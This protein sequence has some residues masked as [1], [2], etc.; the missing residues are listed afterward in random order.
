MLMAESYFNLTISPGDCI[1]WSGRKGSFRIEDLFLWTNSEL[2]GFA[3]RR[4]FRFQ[5][6][7]FFFL[8]P[9]PPPAEHLKP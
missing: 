3:G 1:G 8:T 6:L 2:N 4:G 7:C 5:L 9:D